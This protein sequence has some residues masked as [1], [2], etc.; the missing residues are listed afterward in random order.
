[1]QDYQNRNHSLSKLILELEHLSVKETIPFYAFCKTA[2]ILRS[3]KIKQIQIYN[4]HFKFLFFFFSQNR[5]SGNPADLR[6][7]GHQQR[8]ANPSD[9]TFPVAVIP[10]VH[11][12]TRLPICLRIINKIENF[13]NYLN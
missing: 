12:H 10:G 6:L 1:M 5:I 4:Q 9:S 2:Q 13:T 11:Q 7:A 8:L 3:S